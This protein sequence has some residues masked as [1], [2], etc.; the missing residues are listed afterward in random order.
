MTPHGSCFFP[1]PK[2]H[3]PFSAP[4][5]T[6]A[7]Q[8]SHHYLPFCLAIFS[9]TRRLHQRTSAF[10]FVLQAV[11]LP[12]SFP[13]CVGER[14]RSRCVSRYSLARFTLL[15]LRGHPN[16]VSSSA[17]LCYCYGG[18]E[19]A[20]SVACARPTPSLSSSSWAL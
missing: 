2:R 8:M 15:L 1:T 13:P 9:C 11:S 12:P 7:Q 6:I 3:R 20:E 10:A 17:L 4:P 18:G 14:R 5:T 19:C 16:F